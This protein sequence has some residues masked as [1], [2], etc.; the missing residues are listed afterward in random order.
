MD[1]EAVEK[2]LASG[3]PISCATCPFF[4]DG[5][6]HCG[7]SECG[8]PGAGRDFPSYGGPIPREKFAE[9]CLVCGSSDPGFMIVGLDTKFGLCKKHAK[10][11][12]H[13]G[14]EDPDKLRHPVTVI[15]LR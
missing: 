2:A 12:E 8:G 13:V 7:K 14:Q 15:A 5:N 4:H 10:V 3:A 1:Q 6:S 11:Y 9:R